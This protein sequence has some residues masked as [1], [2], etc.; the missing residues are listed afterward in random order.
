MLDTPGLVEEVEQAEHL[1]ARFANAKNPRLT[2][3][4]AARQIGALQ[5]LVDA[6]AGA[7]SGAVSSDKLF[8]T[9]KGGFHARHSDDGSTK[10]G[11]GGPPC[12]L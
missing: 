7:T 1:F 8:W 3:H 5:P 6:V 10:F 12:V 2:L 4:S 11:G 9:A